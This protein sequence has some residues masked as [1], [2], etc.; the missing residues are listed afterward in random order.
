MNQTR[1]PQRW[2][3]T[4]RECFGMAG[5]AAAVVLVTT[6][7]VTRGWADL[8]AIG[9]CLLYTAI[10]FVVFSGITLL[11]GRILRNQEMKDPDRP[12]LD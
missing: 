11:L 3:I 12:V 5:V 1:E 2:T 8:K 6:I 10:T 7:I 9:L 4:P